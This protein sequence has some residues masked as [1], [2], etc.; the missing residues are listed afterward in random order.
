MR[1]KTSVFPYIIACLLVFIGTSLSAQD[2]TQA[3]IDSTNIQEQVV[4]EQV[5]TAISI[6]AVVER[7]SVAIVPRRNRPKF[8]RVMFLDRNFDRELKAVPVKL[9]TLDEEL[10]SAKKI[11]RLKKLLVKEKK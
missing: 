7:P 9:I 2:T 6:I 1:F 4:E 3:V 8:E 10:E 5:L 11:E